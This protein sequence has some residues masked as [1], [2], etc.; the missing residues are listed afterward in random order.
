M[1]DKAL[2][3]APAPKR[4][5]R[6]V[7]KQVAGRVARRAGTAARDN[8]HTITAALAGAFLGYARSKGMKLPTIGKLTQEQTAALAGIGA[9]LFTKNRTVRHVT[10]GLVAVAAYQTAQDMAG[11]SY[12]DVTVS[13]RDDVDEESVMGVDL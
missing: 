7:V 11:K 12:G 9:S 8:K 4:K 5:V 2:A 13:G 1:A 3:T 10:T 6:T